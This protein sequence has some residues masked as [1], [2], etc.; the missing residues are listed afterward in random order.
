MPSHNTDKKAID[1]DIAGESIENINQA[2]KPNKQ[3]SS[4]RAR[5]RAAIKVN[6]N[7]QQLDAF[8]V[9]QF[10]NQFVAGEEEVK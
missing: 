3:Q 2:F 8:N 10:D 1:L 4:S 9:S 7:L 6:K 5:H